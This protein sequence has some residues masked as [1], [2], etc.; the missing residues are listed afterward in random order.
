MLRDKAPGGHGK[1]TLKRWI[2]RT[3]LLYLT[4]AAVLVI[5][6]P[7]F[8]GNKMRGQ[9]MEANEKLS[10]VYLEFLDS[11]VEGIN[12]VLS[13]FAVSSQDISILARSTDML[14]RYLAKYNVM[15]ELKNTSILYHMFDGIFVKSD[16]ETEALF[17]CQVG[18][19]GNG[20]QVD[21]M[22]NIMESF[23]E[24]YP[25]NTWV[26]I[27]EEDTDYLLRVVTGGSTSCGAWIDA[28]SLSIPLE[29]IDYS[30]TGVV[31]FVD[32]DGD[33]VGRKE[34]ELSDVDRLS[35]DKNGNLIQREGERYL[36]IMKSSRTLPVSMA[37]LVPEEKYTGNIYLIQNIIGL[38]L[39]VAFLTIPLLWRMISGS[40]SRPVEQLV[41]SMNEV[42]KGN[43]SIRVKT[44]SRFREFVEIGTY[45]NNMVT[46]IGRLQ[47]DVYK[48]KI[49]EQRIQL[50]YL[51]AQIRPHFFLNTLNVIHSFSL[52]KRNDLI[53]QM[54]VCLSRY[55]S[56]RF[57]DPD[58]MV[59]LRAEKEHIENYLQLHR[60][61]YQNAL[62]CGLE[63]EEVLLD[64]KIPPLVIQTFVENS[65]KYGMVSTRNLHLEII[66]EAVCAD[67]RD[68]GQK[69]AGNVPPAAEP[70]RDT[71]CEQ[72]LCITITD[73]GPG[74]E[75]EV[76]EAVRNGKP[77][78]KGHGQGIGIN[79]VIQR[80]KLLYG[81]AA[82]VRLSNTPGAGAC[83][84][85]FLPLVFM[86]EEGSVHG[87]MIQDVD[88]RSGGDYE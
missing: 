80:L 65:L 23:V 61:R 86:E 75:E 72:K 31:L 87:G 44:E 37:I 78:K 9:A 35:A 24:K 79:N 59:S 42:Q 62:F 56:Y 1:T 54:V 13:Q 3:M 5:V 45:F 34:R 81:E 30:D 32:A 29:K 20:R 50:Q 40:V 69:E 85:I 7:W 47:E 76:L 74:Y 73:N 58:A 51:Q 55:F 4:V 49:R 83:C 68:G 63:M 27:R 16:S 84:E 60:L 14:E 41:G 10:E 39:A 36:Q 52:I 64:A 48:R 2:V 19:K 25:A 57:K 26:L 18:Q 38:M 43:L 66:A 17:L 53:E 22:K 88:V 33:A 12:K 21:D 15:Q 67:R 70:G 77:V 82:W 11:N 6:V 8:I 28:S 71:T 46:E